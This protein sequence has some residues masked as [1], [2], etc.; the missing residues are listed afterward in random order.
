MT[1]QVCKYRFFDMWALR[2]SGHTYLVFFFWDLQLSAFISFFLS[3]SVPMGLQL[4][5]FLRIGSHF[6][7]EME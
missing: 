6:V 7:N 4:A 3:P 1:Y 2:K 5:D